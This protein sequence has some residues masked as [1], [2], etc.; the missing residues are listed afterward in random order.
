M[1]RIEG[2]NAMYAE[3]LVEALE[4]QALSYA[5]RILTEMDRQERVKL[6]HPDTYRDT[7]LWR[8]SMAGVRTLDEGLHATCAAMHYITGLRSYDLED[9]AMRVA[10][11]L[12]R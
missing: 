11:Y 3:Q 10:R 6:Q 8:A 5:R 12:Y 7:R 2:L 1:A 4:K 9:A